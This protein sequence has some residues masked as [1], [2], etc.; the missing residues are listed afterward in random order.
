MKCLVWPD[1]LWVKLP[2]NF[3]ANFDG[4]FLLQKI[5]PSFS[6]A[7]GPRKKFTKFTPRIVGISL[8]FHFL[9]PK[10]CFTPIFCLRGRPKCPADGVLRIGRGVSPDRARKIWLTPSESFA[11]HGLPLRDL[12]N[13]ETGGIQFRRVRFQTPNSVS[14]SG[15]TEFRGAN[16][17]SSFSPIICV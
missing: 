15:L 10:S 4:D 1:E 14:F 17:V 11:R 3:S 8:Q 12:L 7:S 13:S 5:R 6:R 16:S 9:E 2:A